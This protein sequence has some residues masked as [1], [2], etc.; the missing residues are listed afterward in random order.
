M[1]CKMHLEVVRIMNKNGIKFKGYKSFT[2][3][4]ADINN[5]LISMYL[6]NEII[7][8]NQVFWEIPWRGEGCILLPLAG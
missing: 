1:I 4:Y 7:V 3:D 6:L 5:I 2:D 8:E